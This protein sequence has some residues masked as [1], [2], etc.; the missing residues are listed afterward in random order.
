MFL[1]PW[2]ILRRE[3]ELSD[4]MMWTGVR[5]VGMWGLRVRGVRLA[6]LRPHTTSILTWPAV[7]LMRQKK[8]CALDEG[9]SSADG[10]VNGR[11]RLCGFSWKGVRASH[12]APLALCT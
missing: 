12:V 9:Y 10:G 3:Q 6:S 4:Q 11:L 2:R 7:S 1:L 8:F 5:S